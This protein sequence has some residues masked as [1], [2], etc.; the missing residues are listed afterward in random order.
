VIYGRNPAGDAPEVRGI[1]VHPAG[2][3]PKGTGTPKP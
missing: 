2:S 3:G 1:V